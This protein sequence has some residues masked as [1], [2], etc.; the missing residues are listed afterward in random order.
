MS[1]TINIDQQKE[2]IYNAITEAEDH[3]K[4]IRVNVCTKAYMNL[5]WTQH[6]LDKVLLK[7]EM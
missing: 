2:Q 4:R 1:E 3:L 5:D 6:K 7:L